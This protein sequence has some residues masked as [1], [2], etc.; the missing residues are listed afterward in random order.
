MLREHAF[1]A[2][3]GGGRGYMSFRDRFL[4]GQ[5][6]C[7]SKRNA[8]EKTTHNILEILEEAGGYKRL[9]FTGHY[10][11]LRRIK[12]QMLKLTR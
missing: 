4:K 7:K 1:L 6:F 3:L 5:Y 10:Y 9:I 11:K 8:V 12:G 2:K